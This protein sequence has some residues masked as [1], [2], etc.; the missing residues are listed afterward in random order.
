M[1]EEATHLRDVICILNLK[2]VEY[3]GMIQAY[4]K[5]HSLDGTEIKRLS[6][7]CYGFFLDYI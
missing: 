1:K 2:H 4:V 3:D 7:V 6:G 5:S